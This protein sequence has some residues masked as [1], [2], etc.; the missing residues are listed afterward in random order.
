[1]IMATW[2]AAQADTPVAI[3]SSGDTIEAFVPQGFHVHSRKEA[4]FN[5]DG[6]VDAVLVLEAD[7]E[8]LRY[9]TPRPLVVLFAKAGGGYRLSARSD[10]VVY[11]AP[12][13]VHGDH[14]MGVELRGNSFVVKDES[15]G[16]VSGGG[17]SD[18]Y[19]FRNG[20]WVRIG[21]RESSYFNDPP[22]LTCEGAKLRP[23]EMVNEIDRDTNL[24]TG[25]EIVKCGILHSEQDFTR[26]V[27]VRRKVPVKPLVRLEEVKENQVTGSG[28]QHFRCDVLHGN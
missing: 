8:A 27:T 2:A 16:L 15:G 3:P 12:L 17:V 1:V 21:R 19:Q 4:D 10:E 23:H 26:T 24:L 25:D 11:T 22:G 14:F 20:A 5:G 6:L 13:G 18:Q 9:E 28:I 7:D